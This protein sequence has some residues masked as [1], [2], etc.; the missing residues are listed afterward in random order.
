MRKFGRVLLSAGLAAAVAWTTACGSG[1]SAESAQPAEPVVD[2][3]KLDVGNLPTQPK[4][5]D[6]PTAI[7]MAQLVE[8]WRLAEYV[9]LPSEVI[10]EV[11][12]RAQAMGTVV[13]AF[14]DFTSGAIKSRTKADGTAM[15]AAA[16][17]LVAGFVS[18]GKSDSEVSLSYELEN[19]VMVFKDEQSASDAAQALGKLDFESGTNEAVRIEK[20]P[21]AVAY[22]E[23]GISGVGGPLRS[24]YASGKF[25]VFTYVYDS[26][27]SAVKKRDLPKLLNRVE[28]SLDV[29]PP[30]VAK[31]PA[32]PWDKLME[33]AV[34]P[35]KMLGRA[36]PTVTAD[37]SQPGVPGVYGPHAALH[38]KQGEEEI[39][40]FAEA[41][42]DRLGF[43][44][45]TVY[46]ARD[47][48]GAA[49]IVTEHA[50]TSR[51]FK[52]AESPT[53]LPNA[54][55]RKYSGPSIAISYYCFVQH[56]RYAAEVSANQLL[57]AQQRI[58]AQYATLVNAG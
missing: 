39:K 24:W 46:R 28:R 4:V 40:L 27:M 10:P 36:L 2:L 42:V 12:Y 5:Y 48:A 33:L 52:A 53:G 37:S 19:L 34:D 17:G 29:I 57:D 6:K 13:R 26:V 47:A 18:T 20:Y 41:G 58:S 51:Q 3:S 1:S 16:P 21:A 30:A 11:K 54:K 50:Q 35:D 15:N 43:R 9:P 55:C 23:N 44:G 8:A 38:I 7:E 14:Q 56:G 45:G 32:T 25:V 22:I 31:F 49:K